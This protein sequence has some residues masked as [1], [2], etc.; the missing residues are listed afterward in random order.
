MKPDID[1]YYRDIPVFEQATA[2][3]SL[4]A[5][6]TLFTGR[7]IEA[8]CI[9]D[10]QKRC[11]HAVGS[12]G[13]FLCGYPLE[14]VMR[15]GYDFFNEALHPEDVF[16]WA[17]MHN[18]ILKS[19]H[20]EVFTKEEANYFECSFRLK[21]SIHIRLLPEYLMIDM[22]LVPVWEHGQL[23][24]G[25]CLYHPSVFKTS[26]NLRVYF[27]EGKLYKQYS[28]RA[29]KWKSERVLK[30]S[31]RE[32]EILILATQGMS[33]KE[34]ADMLCINAKS[35]DNTISNLFEKLH[36]KSMTQAILHATNRR[37]IFTAAVSKPQLM[38]KKQENL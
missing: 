18:N 3:N 25:I 38:R 22:K 13:L 9:L 5:N 28:F 1:D 34:M 23:T 36:V 27:K 33:R 32:R 8:T 14:T 29:Q 2:G 37:L 4:F 21:S 7:M 6:H 12:H 20:N 30:I 19:L 26:G 11:F 24:Y 35:L 10:F 31:R 17:E 16:L 15:M